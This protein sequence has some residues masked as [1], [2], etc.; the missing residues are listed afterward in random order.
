MEMTKQ[1]K[2]GPV[3]WTEEAKESFEEIKRVCAKDA[4]LHYPDFN[5]VFEIHT[6]SSNYQMG[7]II[8]QKGRP[9]AYW[10]KKLSETQQNY[11]TTDQELLAWN[12]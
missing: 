3:V 11:P 12:D 6:D 9:I 2:K 10:S 1:K 4:L 5:D 7:A 8:S